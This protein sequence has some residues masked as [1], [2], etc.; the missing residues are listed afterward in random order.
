MLTGFGL[1]ALATLVVSL[2][3]SVGRGGW[4]LLAVTVAVAGELGVALSEVDLFPAAG[5]IVGRDAGAGRALP[6]AVALLGSP[7]RTLATSLWIA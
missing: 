6:A 7:A 1:V 4:A 5:L 3:E 2:L